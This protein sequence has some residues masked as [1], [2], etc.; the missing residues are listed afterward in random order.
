MEMR[1]TE[2][3]KKPVFSL[4]SIEQPHEDRRG[5]SGINPRSFKLG[6]RLRPLATRSGFLT[7]YVAEW[8]SA[9]ECWIWRIIQRRQHW[10]FLKL[11]A[12]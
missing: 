1:H 9:K 5:N 8:A 4:C 7:S 12:P 3:Y 10:Y 6:T 11:P 2:I